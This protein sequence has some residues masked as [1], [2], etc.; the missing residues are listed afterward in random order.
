MWSRC[1]LHTPF[2]QDF[3]FWGQLHLLAVP[4]HLWC[5]RCCGTS[6]PWWQLWLRAGLTLPATVGPWT[7]PDT[8][9]CL[10]TMAKLAGL[11]VYI[12]EVL[13]GFW[14]LGHCWDWKCFV[15]EFSWAST[16]CVCGHTAMDGEGQCLGLW[17]RNTAGRTQNDPER[18]GT[19]ESK[20]AQRTAVKNIWFC[21]RS[22]G[23][24]R[25]FVWEGITVE[26]DLAE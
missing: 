8:W 10:S 1:E 7:D 6:P 5:E 23:Q 24:M 3:Q 4:E 13:A 17:D 20:Q 21:L 22:S 12:L 18:T 11:S 15:L 2:Q 25:S 26:A 16:Q 19:K 14:W 9:L